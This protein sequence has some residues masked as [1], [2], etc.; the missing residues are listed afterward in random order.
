MN[1][2]K[3]LQTVFGT[4]FAG[5]IAANEIVNKKDIPKLQPENY[6]EQQSE[7]SEYSGYQSEEST[8][9]MTGYYE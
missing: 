8:I 7:T 3:F 2:K 6:K 9:Y 5:P 4:M 1:R